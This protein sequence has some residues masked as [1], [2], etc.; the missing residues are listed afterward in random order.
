[1]DILTQYYNQGGQI[2]SRSTDLATREFYRDAMC[3]H[4]FNEM[5]VAVQEKKQVGWYQTDSSVKI[6][7]ANG[8]SGEPTL[9]PGFFSSP[10]SGSDYGTYV[11]VDGYNGSKA[12]AASPDIDQYGNTKTTY[13]LTNKFNS[14]LNKSLSLSLI[15]KNPTNS[16]HVDTK[17]AI[18]VEISSDEYSSGLGPSVYLLCYGDYGL[19]GAS[20]GSS[21]V[22]ASNWSDRY[23]FV[24]GEW[25]NYNFNLNKDGFS[26]FSIDGMVVATQSSGDLFSGNII[27]PYLTLHIPTAD[28]PVN[29]TID[30]LTL[31]IL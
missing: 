3:R 25:H 19:A 5:F 22:W 15:A 6:D 11:S 20:F 16:T 31:N 10:P 23:F 26:T 29:Y 17:G 13:F 8:Y 18:Y 4:R 28:S 14:I 21:P 30:S 1:M 2:I 12:I 9:Y 24:D 27:N 7:F